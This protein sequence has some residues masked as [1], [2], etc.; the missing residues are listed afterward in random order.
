MSAASCFAGGTGGPAWSLKSQAA[1]QVPV[2]GRKGSLPQGLPLARAHSA[3]RGV[4]ASLPGTGPQ[5]VFFLCHGCRHGVADLRRARSE[6]IIVIIIIISIDDDDDA[7]DDDQ[8]T[9]IMTM[10]MTMI[11]TMITRR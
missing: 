2:G 1:A 6:K 7:D 8:N 4:P 9:M 10:L 5:L 3:S 11:F